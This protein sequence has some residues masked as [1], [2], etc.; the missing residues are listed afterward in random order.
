M[1]EENEM[2]NFLTGSEGEVGLKEGLGNLSEA[3]SGLV[4]KG[5]M[6][7]IAMAPPPD[8]TAP[9]EEVQDWSDA[10][11]LLGFVMY[12]LD[13]EDWM[14]E[15]VAYEEEVRDAIMDAVHEAH[16]KDLRKK[17]TVIDGGKDVAVSDEGE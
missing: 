9:T 3:H 12:A 15:Y 7:R 13:R 1:L 5:G 17:F 2:I 10:C 11:G 14:A 6:V 4:F 8:L 16:H